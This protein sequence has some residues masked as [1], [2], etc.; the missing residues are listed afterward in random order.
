[1]PRR[2]A[3]IAGWLVLTAAAT[4]GN[5]EVVVHLKNGRSLRGEVVEQTT[6]SLRF[7][8][9]SGIMT[10]LK[11]EDIRSIE[12][13]VPSSPR[14]WPAPRSRPAGPTAPGLEHSKRC[15]A[16]CRLCE[17]MFRYSLDSFCAQVITRPRQAPI[18][19]K[20]GAWPALQ[21]PA[22]SVL[23]LVLLGEGD[24]NRPGL[25]QRTVLHLTKYVSTWAER[26]HTWLRGHRTW[27]VA[28]ATLFLSE[29]HRMAPSAALRRKIQRLVRLLASA[30]Q[31]AE[32]WGHTFQRTGYGPFVGV[33]IWCAAA[34]ASAKEQG[35][36][37][38]E[39]DLA[40]AYA[41]LRRSIGRSGGASYYTDKRSLVSVGRTGGVLW[42]LRRYAGDERAEVRRGLG[43][44]MRHV[45]S[46]P[47]GHASGLMNFA[48]AALGAAASNPT[49][50]RRFWETHHETLLKARRRTGEFAVQ[51]WKDLGWH[52]YAESDGPG[53]AKGTTWPDPMYG[54]AWATVWMLLAWQVG[55]GRCVLARPPNG[56]AGE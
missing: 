18:A 37:V 5:A 43:F 28:F 30:R 29:L 51:P 52:D 7:R 11:P 2:H 33:T 49:A 25:H 15:P 36:A 24:A 38:D 34:L 17:Q 55:R 16:D 35:V 27:T 4:A 19:V 21:V 14:P 42:V 53:E 48:W 45:D 13:D 39:K 6:R 44:L 31:G 41:G 54:D 47:H 26:E 10:E 23:G 8:T 22:C 20:L 3:V 40:A 9:A 56:V 50:H 12:A 46:A 1:M 32:G